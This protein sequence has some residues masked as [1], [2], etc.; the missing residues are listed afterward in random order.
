MTRNIGNVPSLF[1]SCT[2]WASK[3]C[4]FLLLH[5]VSTIPPMLVVFHYGIEHTAWIP[6]IR[7]TIIIV[8]PGMVVQCGT[9]PY[10]K[11]FLRAA[12]TNRWYGMVPYLTART[13]NGNLPDHPYP[14]V[15]FSIIIEVN[16]RPMNRF[17][18]CSIN[19]LLNSHS[20]GLC[21]GLFSQYI[22]V[23][24]E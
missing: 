14:Y 6:G 13:W 1:Q 21:K 10:C 15:W 23:L 16:I 22:D 20:Y 4:S 7:A 19:P 9:V 17:C 8:C 12:D 3:V 5:W 2:P 18:G 24:E 11:G